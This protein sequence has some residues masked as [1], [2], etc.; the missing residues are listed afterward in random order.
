MKTLIDTLNSLFSSDEY[1]LDGEGKI[2]KEKIKTSA[3]KMDEHLLS[4]LLSNDECK[5]AFFKDVNGISVFDKSSFVW[6]LN[7]VEFLPS[8][9]TSFKNKIGLVNQ[10]G[11]FLTS[12]DDVLL[13]FPFKDCLLEFDSTDEDED[14]KEVFLNETLAKDQIDTLL[15]DKSF[16]KV[17]LHTKDGVVDVDMYNGENLLIKGNNLIA[18]HS[19]KK[20]FEGRIKFMYWDILY[21]TESDKVPYADS[22]KHSSWLTMM[23][24]R[25]EAAIPL[26]TE[27]GVIVLQCDDSEMAYLKV[28]CDEIFDRSNLINVISVNMTT[29][30]GPKVTHAINGKCFPKTK[31]YLLMYA[32]NKQSV[33][34]TIPKIHKEGWGG[35]YDRIIPEWKPEDLDMLTNLTLD[36]DECNERIKDYTIVSLSE[37]CKK[38]GIKYT[39]KWFWENAYRIFVA[40]PNMSLLKMYRDIETDRPIKFVKT[41]KGLNKLIITTFNREA[42]ATNIELASAQLKSE[43][44]L[45]DN[46]TDVD[47]LITS[48]HHEGGVQLHNGKKPE[49]LIKRLLDTCTKPT[50]IVL[51]A[52]S[53]SGTT[54]AACLKMNRRFIAIEQLDSHFE[55]SIE[56]LTGVLQGETTGI[57]VDVQWKGGGSF[58]SCEL[59]KGNASIV[60]KIMSASSKEELISILGTIKDNPHIL[61]YRVNIDELTNLNTDS[62]ESMSLEETKKC[63]LS[64]IEKNTLY[65]NY[66]DIEDSNLSKEEKAFTKSFY[67]SEK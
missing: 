6:V 44:Y 22:F 9:Y 32:K 37:Y 39:E 38:N 11:E 60:E 40:D 1:F 7:N 18:M 56:R 58:I 66:S 55:K 25:L 61:N 41:S 35:R 45:S 21:N 2:L 47:M 42:S 54:A 8:S 24:N 65:L 33:K 19:L 30:S 3:L 16:E 12:I 59:A 31:E 5:N 10:N 53:G 52:Y 64:I 17:K 23:K 14:R 43:M 46:W 26:L 4:L 49:K 63:L 34:L 28:L 15:S 27:D 20:Q 50:D 13:S 57:S 51:D 67:E 36:I 48:I 29:V 62:F